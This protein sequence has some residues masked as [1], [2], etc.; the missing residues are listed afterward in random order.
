[1][2]NLERFYL[3]DNAIKMLPDEICELTSLKEL[4]LSYNQL[5]LFPQ[6]IGNLQNLKIL[7]IIDLP[8][9]TGELERIKKLLPNCELVTD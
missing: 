4:G 6:K 1:M 5:T 3:T 9:K 8:L 2:K 7:R